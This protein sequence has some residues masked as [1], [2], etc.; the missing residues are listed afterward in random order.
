MTFAFHNLFSP[1][2]GL[3]ACFVTTTEPEK[4]PIRPK[5][6]CLRVSPMQICWASK[7][8]QLLLDGRGKSKDEGLAALRPVPIRMSVNWFR[9]PESDGRTDEGWGEK[10]GGEHRKSLDEASVSGER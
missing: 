5:W 7:V 8:L 2:V 10:R 4:E 6:V 1:T 9:T 3:K